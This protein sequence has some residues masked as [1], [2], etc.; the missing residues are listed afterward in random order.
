[1]KKMKTH[2]F[3]AFYNKD[4]FFIESNALSYEDALEEI[5]DPNNYYYAYT[6]EVGLE[7]IKRL[8]L[9]FKAKSQISDNEH[10]KLTGHEMGVASGRV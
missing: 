9:E 1:M 5:R 7:S 3:N 4:G 2:Y 6:I 8:D 10:E